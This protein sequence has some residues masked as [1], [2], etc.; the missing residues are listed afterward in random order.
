MQHILNSMPESEELQ[1]AVVKLRK[2]IKR[3]GYHGLGIVVQPDIFKPETKPL[4]ELQ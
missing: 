1:S 2:A 3:A 4:D